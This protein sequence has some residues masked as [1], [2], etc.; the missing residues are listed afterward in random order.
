MLWKL[1][2]YRDRP[3]NEQLLLERMPGKMKSTSRRDRFTTG[4]YSEMAPRRVGSG[5]KRNASIQMRVPIIVTEVTGKKVLVAKW[6][7]TASQHSGRKNARTISANSK[8]TETAELHS[9]N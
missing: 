3:R 5:R 6:S 9:T 1:T 7:E 2:Y 4:V 8:I